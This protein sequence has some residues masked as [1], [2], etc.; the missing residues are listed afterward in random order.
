MKMKKIL[1]IISTLFSMLPA[2]S[3]QPGEFL[4]RGHSHNDYLQDKPLYR[5]L[6]LRFASI[7]VDVHAFEGSVRVAHHG[8]QLHRQPT[9]EELYLQPLQAWLEQ[10]DNSIYNNGGQL[11]M[12]IDLKSKA[13]LLQDLL[14]RD[15]L[16]YL[17][18]IDCDGKEEEVSAPLKILLSGKPDIDA[19][20]RDT[21]ALF[22]IDGRPGLMN[23][24]IPPGRMPRISTNYKHHFGW[25]GKGAMPA[26]E[27][28]VLR[29]LVSKVHASGRKLRFWNCP[30]NETVWQLLLDEGVDWINVDD[31]GRFAAFMQTYQAANNEDGY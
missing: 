1:F 22:T 28:A 30:E 6:A 16:P 4:D 10:F 5:A 25:N 18:L 8:R 9:L 23:E 26:E 20:L 14:T 12:M 21:L 17:H 3:A 13:D 24:A 29:Q 2:I 7:E 15:L 31:L 19:V 11:I 27:L